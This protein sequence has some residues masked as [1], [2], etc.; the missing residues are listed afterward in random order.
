LWQKI[1]QKIT[2]LTLKQE[3]LSNLEVRIPDDEV[4]DI[5]DFPITLRKGKRLCV[6]YLISM[7][8]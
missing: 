5:D 4:S 7:S 3:E 6:K 8:A 1:S 2:T